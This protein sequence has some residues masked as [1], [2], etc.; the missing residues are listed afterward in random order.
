MLGLLNLDMRLYKIINLLIV[1]GHNFLNA[2]TNDDE[3]TKIDLN[4]VNVQVKALPTIFLFGQQYTFRER[5]NFIRGI[6]KSKWF[7]KDLSISLDLEEFYT[8]RVF[9]FNHKGKVELLL[10]SKKLPTNNKYN[11]FFVDG[12]A[13]SDLNITR[14]ISS[15]KEV[16]I[17]SIQ[18]SIAQ[19]KILLNQLV[20]LN[21]EISDIQVSIDKY[22]EVYDDVVLSKRLSDKKFKQ[23]EGL[24]KL[25]ILQKNYRGLKRKV[26]R[27]RL[28]MES[29]ALLVVSIY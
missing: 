13:Y 29:I 22:K 9:R 14:L 21:N 7:L 16:R 27:N 25:S 26:T 1:F 4:N 19:R 3:G 6:L 10:K 12:A 15:I 2:Q 23:I 24:E 17:D 11:S 8:N 28:K 20:E 18:E 5:D